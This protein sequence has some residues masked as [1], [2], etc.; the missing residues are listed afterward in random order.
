MK[1]RSDPAL[2]NRPDLAAAHRARVMALQG[3]YEALGLAGNQSNGG[4]PGRAV[5][6]NGKRYKS[7]IEASRRTGIGD[8][9]IQDTCNGKALDSW[10][11]TARWL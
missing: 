6:V 8:R 3:H 9:A 1:A 10:M 4:H 11:F 5:M 2:L 7:T